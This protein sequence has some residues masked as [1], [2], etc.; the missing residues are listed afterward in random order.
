MVDWSDVMKLNNIDLK[1][2]Q[3]TNL[4]QDETT[5]AMCDSISEQLNK[6]DTSKC[7]L[8]SNIDNLSEDILDEL[9]IE[10]N[11]FWYDSNA[12]IDTKRKLIQNSEKVFRTLGTNH[13][14]EQVVIDY[15]GNGKVEDWYQ[16]GGQPYHFRVATTNP[17]VTGEVVEQ[18]KEAVKKVKRLSTRLDEV[19][20][21]VNA[22]L[23]INYGF[24]VH[25]G[26]FV[27]VEQGA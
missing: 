15:F 11:I 25:T 8:V 10:K 3:T 26:T 20:V 13:A 12:D 14:V 22:N 19:I 24:V 17:T 23:S 9:S 4:K 7:L 6:I 21:E 2:L 1:K 5:A 27:T 16:Y 18:L